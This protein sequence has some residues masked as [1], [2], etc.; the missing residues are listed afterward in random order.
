MKKKKCFVNILKN[1]IGLKF[2][3]IN[4]IIETNQ[5]T[6]LD[7]AKTAEKISKILIRMFSF[8]D[9]KICEKLV[10]F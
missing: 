7:L 8:F 6:I 9:K 4:Y 5:K 1:F 3:K 10:L 2:S